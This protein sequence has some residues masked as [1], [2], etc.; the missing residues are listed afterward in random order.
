MGKAESAYSR[1]AKFMTPQLA[2][3]FQI[4]NYCSVRRS[5]NA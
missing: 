1:D 3:V 4:K 5:F 2:L